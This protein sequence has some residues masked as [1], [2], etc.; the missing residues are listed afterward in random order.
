ML[1]S[2]NFFILNDRKPPNA[3]PSI[4]YTGRLLFYPLSD[5]LAPFGL[6]LIR[7]SRVLRGVYRSV[8]FLGR[9]TF[10]CTL[11]GLDFSLTY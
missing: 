4:N 1:F 7:M 8:P 11:F 3:H 2:M 10:G 6:G 9:T 5:P